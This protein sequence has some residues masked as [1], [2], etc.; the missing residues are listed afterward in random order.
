MENK[1]KDRAIDLLDMQWWY[2]IGQYHNTEQLA[3]YDGMKEAFN[4]LLLLEHSTVERNEQGK[5]RIVDLPQ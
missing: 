2:Y 4:A 1:Y 3:Y 5:H